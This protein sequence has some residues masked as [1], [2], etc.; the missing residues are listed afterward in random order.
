MKDYLAGL[1]GLAKPNQTEL[2]RV[3]IY[4]MQAE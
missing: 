3:F 2:S 1:V 4:C